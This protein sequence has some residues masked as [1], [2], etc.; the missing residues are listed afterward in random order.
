M[1]N[2]V[3]QMCNSFYIP[4]LD[5]S[6][7]KDNLIKILNSAYFND[8]KCKIINIDFVKNKSYH[9]YRSAFVYYSSTPSFAKLTMK[10]GGI[11]Y[12]YKSNEYFRILPNTSKLIDN[13]KLADNN[14]LKTSNSDN[15]ESLELSYNL[16]K[17][18]IESLECLVA[19]IQLE[20]NTLLE[21]II[22]V[23]RDHENIKAR[24]DHLQKNNESED[25]YHNQ[26]STNDYDDFYECDFNDQIPDLENQV[27]NLPKKI[28]ENTQFCSNDLKAKTLPESCYAYSTFDYNLTSN[29]LNSTN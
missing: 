4:L 8:S 20:N 13:V 27:H 5:Y 7:K 19:D 26:F 28:K 16:L 18:R 23:N 11:K 6:I 1:Y 21:Q 22:V 17:D 12:F 9:D 24:L 2:E 29:K 25:L 3:N 14:S 10:K 15:Y